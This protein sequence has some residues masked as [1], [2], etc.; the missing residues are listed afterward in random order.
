MGEE[1]RG[2]PPHGSQWPHPS[3]GSHWTF[4]AEDGVLEL[5]FILAVGSTVVLRVQGC[6]H[7]LGAFKIRKRVQR[8]SDMPRGCTAH[9]GALDTQQILS[10]VSRRT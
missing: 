7:S 6:L 10:Q 8:G 1:A 4:Q 9:E 3:Q 2:S 5:Q